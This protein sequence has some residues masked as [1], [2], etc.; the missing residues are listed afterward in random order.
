MPHDLK[1]VAIVHALK[2]WRHYWM[3][4][5]SFRMMCQLYVAHIQK[6]AKDKCSSL[7]DFPILEE[8]EDVFPEEVP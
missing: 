2:N 7:V 5:K 6:L 8:F 4:R 3:G 1:L